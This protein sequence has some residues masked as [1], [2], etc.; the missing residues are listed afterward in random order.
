GVDRRSGRRVYSDGTRGVLS[1]HRRGGTE[2][3]QHH[4]VCEPGGGGH[5][6][7]AG[8]A[9]AR[10]RHVSGRAGADPRRVLAGGGEKRGRGYVAR[11]SFRITSFSP[12]QVSSIAQ[13]LTSTNPRGRARSRT[14]SSE[15]PAEIGSA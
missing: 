7:G 1:A 2:P 10:G 4:H 8:P 14:V 3:G 11:S 6:R 13:T 15:T 5:R 12:D 9:R